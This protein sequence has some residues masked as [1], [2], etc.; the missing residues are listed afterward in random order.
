MKLYPKPKEHIRSRIKF[1]EDGSYTRLFGSRSVTIAYATTGEV[2]EYRQRR[3][4]IMVQWTRD[5]LAE[6]QREEWA[7]IFRFAEIDYGS[8][9]DLTLFQKPVWHRPDSPT[10]V[11]LLPA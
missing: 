9:F 2:P 10:P 8:L 5:V 4:Q 7:R 6:E 11:P 1:I 3:R